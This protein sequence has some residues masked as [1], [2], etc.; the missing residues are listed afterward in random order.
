VRK[1][2]QGR[3]KIKNEYKNDQNKKEWTDS[4]GALEMKY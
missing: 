3:N 4:T 2:F 1:G